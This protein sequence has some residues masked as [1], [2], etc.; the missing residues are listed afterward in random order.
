MDISELAI[1]LVSAIKHCNIVPFR[2]LNVDAIIRGG[3]RRYTDQLGHLWN[4]LADY[5]VRSGLF[6]RV[7]IGSCNAFVVKSG[8]WNSTVCVAAGYSLVGWVA[9]IVQ[10][11]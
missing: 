9:G 3:L 7:S 5:Y 6:E 1:A 4:S 8:S 11:V 2:S 10:S